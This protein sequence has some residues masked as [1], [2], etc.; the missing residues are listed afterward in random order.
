MQFPVLFFG[1]LGR[2][3][4][5]RFALELQYPII[6]PVFYKPCP[7]KQIHVDVLKIDLQYLIDKGV[8]QRILR[9]KCAF[10][11]FIIPKKD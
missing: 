10:P 7:I 5:I 2:P 3:N 1:Q 6:S 9:S 8:L 4:K 11:T